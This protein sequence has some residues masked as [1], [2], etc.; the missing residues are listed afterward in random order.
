MRLLIGNKNYS[1]WSLRAWLP[2]RHLEVPFE[3]ERIALSEPGYK[4]RIR[5]HS[6][7]GKVP[8]LI[9]GDVTVWDSLAIGEYL[10]DRYPEGGLWP[11]ATVHRA[12]ARS[13]CAEMHSG[14]P[15]LRTHMPMNI[16][17]SYP[18]RGRT[19]AVAADIARIGQIWRECLS[20]S[21]GP[22]LFGA[23]GLMD[24]MYA[25]VAM[26]FL[27]YA[28]ELEAELAAYVDRIWNLPA[29]QEWRAAA[30][31]ETEILAEDEPYR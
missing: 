24:A 1:S 8:V 30:A 23:F 31:A 19:P 16:R 18:G 2:L 28:V 6:P 11:A 10:A 17:S 22:F 3:E 15:E 5:A 4:E 13:Y 20:R 27:T 25:P 21:G 9:D 14:F 12:L 7:A 29:M 26:R